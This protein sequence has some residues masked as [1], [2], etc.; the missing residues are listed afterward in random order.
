MTTLYIRM[1]PKT[2]V[3]DAESWLA[4]SCP[5]ALVAAGGNI[6]REGFAPLAELRNIVPGALRVIVLLAASD[7]TLLRVQIPPMSPARLKAALPGLVEDRLIADP[8]ESALV[9]GSATTDGLRTVAVVQRDWLD[10]IVN[11]FTSFGARKLAVVPLQLCLPYQ[12]GEVSAAVHEIAG[13]L[14][15]TLRTAEQDGIG[16]SIFPENGEPAEHAV[17]Q[18]LQVMTGQ[19]PIAL[20]VPQPDGDA[21]RQ[22]VE[23]EEGLA[24]RVAIHAENW[25]AWIAGVN[26]AGLDLVAG[27][28]EGSGPK[29]DWR[30]W[31]WPIALAGLLLAINIIA[32][33]V[34]W[35]R[36][37]SEA[38][39]LRASM[40]Q[41]YRATFP[42]DTVIVDPL[43][44][45]KQK[46][47]G[48]QRGAPDDFTT[49][50]AVFGEA[51]ASVAQGRG[52][53]GIAGLEYKDRSLSVRLKPG[54]SPPTEQMKAA[55]ASRNLTLTMGP[56][57]AG[58]TVWQIR[59]AR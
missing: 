22:A 29:V 41:I 42:K 54:G 3:S 4:A 30:K 33:N 46:L 16:L 8:S 11:A 43:A 51:W 48:G 55:L 12:S 10:S 7:V 13:E 27:R 38:D 19:A 53:A 24:E 56:S 17:L 2:A 1:I 23:R 58:S 36:M 28:Q 9:A 21:Y 59:S 50:S 57:Q 18:T 34:D 49:L 25:A 6:Q 40:T 37:R 26:G 15:L 39:Q 47:G 31:R 52:T 5:F 32:L 44:Q 35:W 45:M 20:Y 14:E